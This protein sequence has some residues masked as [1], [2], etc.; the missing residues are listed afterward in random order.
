MW[1]CPYDAKAN[2]YSTKNPIKGTLNADGSIT[3]AGWGVFVTEG[4][5][6]G[7]SFAR[8]KGSELEVPNA[9]MTDTLYDIN[10]PSSRTTVLSYPVYID[11]VSANQVRISNFSG[12][13][14]V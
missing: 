1:I 8:F 14:A 10:N 3:L 13:G 2:S 5:Y 6:K 11:S 4:D 7:G 9:V 12:I